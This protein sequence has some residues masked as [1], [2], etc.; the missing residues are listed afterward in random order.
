MLE[1][2]SDLSEHFGK[3]SKKSSEKDT[4]VTV[5]EIKT[6][7]EEEIP[8][9][10][11]TISDNERKEAENKNDF[12]NHNDEYYDNIRQRMRERKILAEKRRVRNN[13]IIAVLILIVLASIIYLCCFRSDKKKTDDSSTQVEQNTVQPSTT[14][15]NVNSQE[16]KDTTISDSGDSENV[17]E[18]SPKKTKEKKSP[19]IVKKNGMTFVNGILIVNK[20]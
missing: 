19:E 17:K 12:L 11:D 14:T 3:N 4:D 2:N 15:L 18:S 8:V 7:I 10:S 1:K 5:R 20:T 6:D 16:K 9:K 13:R